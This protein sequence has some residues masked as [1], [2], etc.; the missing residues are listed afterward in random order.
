VQPIDF[1]HE[2]AQERSDLVCD[3]ARRFPLRTGHPLDQR[4]RCIA[5]QPV[6]NAVPR[7]QT[8]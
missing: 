5:A 1:Y 3:N 2:M 8:A 7:L 6:V 4:L